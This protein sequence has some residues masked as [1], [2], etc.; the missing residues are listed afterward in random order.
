[1]L[2]N[3]TH[4]RKFSCKKPTRAIHSPSGW[5]PYFGTQDLAV[6]SPFNRADHCSS[7]STDVYEISVDS[8][9]RNML[10]NQCGSWF[11]II[12]LEVWSIRKKA[13]SSVKVIINMLN[14]YR[15][16]ISRKCTYFIIATPSLF[17][18]YG[19]WS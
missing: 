16:E 15:R 7:R 6:I 19:L 8:E 17:I 18:D 11:T 2:F 1:M 5:G 10:T 14:R 3:L 13:D 4:E 12:E 9:G